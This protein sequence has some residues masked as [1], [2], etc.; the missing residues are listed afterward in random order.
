M[1]TS[2]IMYVEEDEYETPEERVCEY[3][4]LLSVE[5]YQYFEN[6]SED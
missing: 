5:Q 6:D 3:S 4:G 1:C 2:G